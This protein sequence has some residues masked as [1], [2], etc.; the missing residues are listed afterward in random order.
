M[1]FRL[2]CP[3]ISA[4]LSACWASA[5][6]VSN[7]KRTALKKLVRINP[8]PFLIVVCTDGR[9][10]LSTQFRWLSARHLATH[11][12]VGAASGTM[13]LS[14]QRDRDCQKESKNYK[15]GCR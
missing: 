4:G 10:E 14:R 11:F 5:G 15:R 1:P 6:I 13:L 12:A 3:P 8:L 9:G 2:G 7:A